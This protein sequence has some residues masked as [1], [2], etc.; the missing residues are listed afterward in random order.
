MIP[1]NKTIL[2]R[3]GDQTTLPCTFTPKTSDGLIVTWTKIPG[4][5]VYFFAQGKEDAGKQEEHYKDRTFVDESRFNEGDF[6]LFLEDM[7][8]SDEGNYQCFVR[9]KPADF[10]SSSLELCVA[11]NYT[12][13]VA[14]CLQSNS[15]GSA[16]E[17]SAVTLSCQTERGYP[18]AQLD[19]TFSNGTRVHSAAQRSAIDSEGLVSIQS[20]LVIARALSENLTIY[21][22]TIP[23]EIFGGT[24]ETFCAQLLHPNESLTFT[25]TM[26]TNADNLTLLEERVK[27]NEFYRCVPFQ[28]KTVE[29]QDPAT[30]RIAQWLDRTSVSGIL[31]LSQP[32]SSE[33]PQGTYTLHAETESGYHISQFFNIKEYVL[34]KYE[35]KVHLPKSITILDTEVTVK[36]CAK[37][38]YGKPVLG[39]VTGKFCRPKWNMYWYRR[40]DNVENNDICHLFNVLTDK[41]GCV[42]EVIDLKEFALNATG[43]SD[44]FNVACD[45]EEEGT[46]VQLSGSSSS[47]FT[48]NVN[49]VS[50]EGA[51]N[52][53]KKG[54][55]FKAK[56]KMTGP[57]SSPLP[58]EKVHLI[59]QWDNHTETMNFTTD[60]RGLVP[61]SLDTSS[62]DTQSV[63]LQARYSL[64]DNVFDYQLVR[65]TYGI[66]DLWLNPFYSKSKSFL[67]IQEN[68]GKLQCGEEAPIS[69]VYIIQG[70][71]LAKGAGFMDFYYLVL[72][73]GSI[74]R[75]G[76]VGVPMKAGQVS[77]GEFSFKLPVSSHL[78]PYA[79]V[80]V[81]A[82]FPNGEI[83]AD[84]F[85]FQVDTCFKNKV[86]LK[87]SA[88]QELPGED[89]TVH[90]RADPGS[91][92]ALRAVDQSVIL[93]EPDKEL[94][95]ETVYNLLPTQKRD[96][97][98]YR[99][100]D[101]E[102]YPCLPS[103]FHRVDKRSIMP[104]Y[105]SRSHNDVYG[106][107]KG[108]GLKILSNSDVKKPIEC[109]EFYTPVLL[110][111]SGSLGEPMRLS[112]LEDT[113]FSS[114]VMFSQADL[115][116]VRK[117]PETVR[118]YFPE[119]WI[120]ELV[121]VGGEQFELK[122]TV[123][124]YLSQCIMVKV[125]HAESS[126]FQM[127]PCEGCEYTTCLCADEARTFRWA[128]IPSALGEVN[129]TVSAQALQTDTLCGNEV[130]AVPERGRIDTVIRKLL[131]EGTCWAGP[132]RTW[133]GSLPCPS[134]ESGDL[135]GRAMQN[136]DRLLAM[137]FGCGEQNMVLFAPNIY[138]LKYLQGTRQLTEAIKAK[139]T[140][141]LESGYQRELNY[142]HE[143]GSY[144]AFG[145]S[146]DSGNTWLTAFVLKSFGGA[147]PFIY[148]DPRHIKDAQDWLGRHQQKNGCF[149]SV[150]KLFHNNMKGGVEDEVS[151]TA[152]ITA[153]LLE[154]ETPL[155]DPVLNNS[156]ACLR[157]A[158]DNI[159][160]TYTTALLSYTFSLAGEQE[161]RSKL[162]TDL[163][164]Q[165]HKTDGSL[166]W[167]RS[168]RDSR[169]S[170]SL[171]V[172][173][174]AYVLMSVLSAPQPSASDLSYASRIVKWLAYQQNPYGGFSSTQDTVVALQ[175]L[176]RYSALVYSPEGSSTLT[177]RSKGGFMRQFHL[178]QSNR[179][180]YQ[181][182][183][184]QEVPGEYSVEA[185]GK[186]CVFVQLALRYN[187]PPPP[188][189][190]TFNISAEARGLCNAT[191]KKTLTVLFTVGPGFN[192]GFKPVK[193]MWW[194]QLVMGH[195]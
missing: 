9:F 38:T 29:L 99:V 32:L 89:T 105:H 72:A 182:E 10:E 176:A 163:E 164:E 55:P 64:L 93:M 149:L 75:N 121:P 156:L 98:S 92:C 119:T 190:S 81:Y 152:Y 139:A 153:A 27:E 102:P 6:T 87:F 91:L 83:V 21:L 127:T 3:V 174:T 180:L 161:M 142:K 195:P 19:W 18:E 71:E 110:S 62:W 61:I 36:I 86:D 189:F 77:E 66:A 45:L 165:A 8:V 157:S 33:A 50:F 138:I 23:S 56:I 120:W 13:P 80:L 140:R 40:P 100:E 144:S 175:A 113:V 181:E 114:V 170:D 11:A 34:P 116:M 57:D 14:S 60:S 103:P 167:S 150:G 187:I 159:T 183:P 58:H 136:L 12:K 24:T 141:F 51:Q 148:I 49:E 53:F 162:L 74:A 104:Y 94:T 4:Q 132:C 73:K 124:N 43:Y 160:N 30:N 125:S 143:D 39:K 48:S 106:I 108:L 191:D 84:S 109:H 65:P 158:A 134:A 25:V 68:E 31:D 178:D 67:K 26:E 117:E 63:R 129:V 96:G 122:A 146:D 145:K 88:P 166:H 28:Y 44:Q 133:T 107:F 131:V 194:V 78:A 130:V 173:M 15:T 192:A 82:V 118:K 101:Y 112:E 186:N 90:L 179:L 135:L 128:F 123:F 5:T 2:S 154:V 155:T 137:P 193:H 79:Q 95:V 41:T 17:A 111:R 168:K 52:S 47:T 7:R 22:V 151:L 169:R 35:V 147:L 184:L 172:E 115:G 69:I 85:D 37:Y 171:E 20:S 188:G 1:N 70:E 177:V 46:G 185:E 76:R 59:I 126:Q 97:Y 16:Q 42:T 54:I